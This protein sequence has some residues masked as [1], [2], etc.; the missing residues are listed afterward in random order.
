MRRHREGMETGSVLPGG[1]FLRLPGLRLATFFGLSTSSAA[2]PAAGGLGKRLSFLLL[3]I[4]SMQ[5]ML[6]IC[7]GGLVSFQYRNFTTGGARPRA[8]DPGLLVVRALFLHP[9][10]RPG[11][12]TG[13]LE[14]PPQQGCH[15]LRL[16][17]G[18]PPVPNWPL[19]PWQPPAFRAGGCAR[20][21]SPAVGRCHGR[22]SSEARR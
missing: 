13:L 10:Q 18:M 1:K 17:M 11:A 3:W 16:A 2:S 20:P 15:L 21:C 22:C 9:G 6:S 14:D 8:L 19:C 7:W 5:Q 12:G 4:S